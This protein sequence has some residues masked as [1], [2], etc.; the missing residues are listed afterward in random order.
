MTPQLGYRLPPHP[1]RKAHLPLRAVVLARL[2]ETAGLEEGQVTLLTIS[3]MRGGG[4]SKLTPRI[5][6]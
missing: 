1:H 3:A 5:L 4:E 6:S 2:C